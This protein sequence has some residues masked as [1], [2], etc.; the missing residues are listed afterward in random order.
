MRARQGGMSLI[1]LMVSLLIGLVLVL[2]VVQALMMSRSAL[3]SQA[4]MAAISENARVSFELM[5]RELRLTGLNATSTSWLSFSQMDDSDHANAWVLSAEGDGATVEYWVNADNEL[6][7]RRDSATPQALVDGIAGMD[8]AFGVGD[9]SDGSL[10]YMDQSGIASLAQDNIWALRIEL[11]LNDPQDNGSELH[12]G[13]RS[14]SSTIALRNPLLNAV[15]GITT[16]PAA[17][18]DDDDDSGDGDNGADDGG[19]TGGD[20]GGDGDGGATDPGDDG[21]PD[22][23]GGDPDPVASCSVSIS[24]SVF[25]KHASINMTVGG[26]SSGSCSNSGANKNPTYSCSGGAYEE[27]AYIVLTAQ[28]GNTVTASFTLDCAGASSV[29]IENKDL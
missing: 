21:D 11:A 17:G 15:A 13:E 23:G 7:Y 20:T 3:V 6:V 9:P 19:D 25:H 27:G 12:F 4:S 2:G 18:S 10:Q 1:E 5:R 8:V 14:I 22:D 24:G 16:A 28:Q 29:T 26:L